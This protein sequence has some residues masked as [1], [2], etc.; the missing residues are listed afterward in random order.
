VALVNSFYDGKS[1]E[2]NSFDVIFSAQVIE[3]I[4]D[5][6]TFI[7]DIYSDLKDD[8][9]LVLIT[10]NIDAFASKLWGKHWWYISDQHVCYYSKNTITKLLQKNG[11][12]VQKIDGIAI[13]H[14]NIEFLMNR[15]D[16]FYLRGRFRFLFNSINAILRYTLGNIFIPI[17][18]M[19]N[20]IVYAYK[21]KL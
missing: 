2:D 12:T 20:M 9:M 5:P 6:N 15:L 14:S 7:A 13:A 16:A 17:N 11:F 18:F 10:G 1:F 8:G 21:T 3:H 4:S 19:D